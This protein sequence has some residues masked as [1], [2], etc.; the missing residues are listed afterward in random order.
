MTRLYKRSASLA[1]AK[2]TP[3]TFFTTTDVLTIAD[4]RVQFS[5]VKTLG[6]HP[7]T[8]KITI[9][10]LAEATRASVQ[11]KPL[12]IRLDAGYDG[13]LRRLFAGDLRWAA[14]KQDGA[15]W[16]TE[17]TG[18]DGDRAY[19]YGFASRSFRAGTDVKT[20]LA[21]AAK[22]AG[23]RIPTSIAEAR[24]L[25]DQVATGITLHEPSRDAL[26]K[27]LKPKGLDWSIQ[28]GSLQVLRSGEARP[29]S[30][31]LVSVDTGMIGSPEYGAP[32]KA[33]AAPV[34]SVTS[35][36]YP[37][38]SPGGT[39]EVFSRSVRGFFRVEQ[40]KHDGD[41]HGDEWTTTIEATAIK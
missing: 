25:L 9:S 7:N 37:E 15:T 36:L 23:L 26:T 24:E 20:V 14:S 5:I 31:L 27:I 33:G 2:I 17:L 8:C 35:L 40:V 10:N 1:I 32:K 16:L 38:V 4:L 3:G 22:S 39:I 13:D 19:R 21:E 30:A 11:K 12:A 41:T 18:G 28:D 6:Q 34:L 29:G